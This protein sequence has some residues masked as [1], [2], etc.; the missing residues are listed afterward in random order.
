MDT[1][2]FD[3]TF[4]LFAIGLLALLANAYL[5]HFLGTM[6][7]IAKIQAGLKE[8]WI[9]FPVKV[10][11]RLFSWRAFF[12]ASNLIFMVVSMFHS[13]YFYGL[14]ESPNDSTFAAGMSQFMGL[15]LAG[16]LDLATIVFM[17]AMIIAKE[18]GEIG[19]ARRI[20]FY[21][22]ICCGLS[23]VGNLV[24]NLHFQNIAGMA[25]VDP[26]FQRVLPFLASTPPLLIIAF[27]LVAEL[28]IK[29][30][31]LENDSLAEFKA[32]EKKKMDFFEARLETR[33]QM[34]KLQERRMTIQL[35]E[36]RN[37]KIARGKD[38]DALSLHKR[39]AR[40]FATVSAPS[41]QPKP[42]EQ[43]KKKQGAAPVSTQK[44]T[45]KL[46]PEQATAVVEEQADGATQETRPNTVIDIKSGRRGRPKGT[47]GRGY[48]PRKTVSRLVQQ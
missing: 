23:T 44:G 17:Q 21:I 32:A 35:L 6:Q 41:V 5:S 28:L 36:I 12:W 27:S 20:L 13:G 10:A 18:R 11:T 24:H 46:L 3:M 45:G 48:T 38:P 25:G 47:T 22:A 43:P 37:K 14:F 9:A 2:L 7:A 30:N 15:A 16:I 39:F 4:F 42:I 40:W 26:L 31:A 33:D 34:A 29:V 1:I 19:R 8:K